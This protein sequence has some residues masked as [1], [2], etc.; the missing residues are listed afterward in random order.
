M[1]TQ[2][3]SPS[4]I[5]KIILTALLITTVVYGSLPASPAFASTFLVNDLS[6]APDASLDGICD[7]SPGDGIE[8][9]TLRA[10]IMEAN[11]VND[12]DVITF[13][14]PMT[15][16]LGSALPTITQPVT[17]DGTSSGGRITLNGGGAPIY[18]FEIQADSVTIKG[19]SLVNFDNHAIQ[20]TNGADGV[21]INNNYIG[22]GADGT[23]D[24]GN[25]H[26]G[27]N[28]IDSPNATISTNLISG[29][30][31][32]GIYVSGAD[33]DGLTI[34]GNTIGLNSAGTARLETDNTLT[35]AD[36]IRLSAVTN[37]TVGGSSGS[38]R[39]VVSGNYGLGIV[40]TGDSTGTKVNGNYV[41]TNAIG[42]D[43]IGNMDGGVR[44]NNALGVSVGTT[45]GNL[46]SGNDASAV[47]V[48]GTSTSSVANN[49]I[50]LDI[51]GDTKLANTG[52]GIGVVNSDNINIY[53]NVISGNTSNGI[54]VTEGSYNLNINDNRI[55]VGKTLDIDLGNSGYGIRLD[56]SNNNLIGSKT[57]SLGNMIAYNGNDGIFIQNT[58]PGSFNSYG[59]SIVGNQIFN[60]A[61]LGIDLAPNGPTLNDA[62]DP[63]DGPNYLQN[64]ITFTA[65]QTATG[66]Q[67]TG[68]LNTDILR[69][70]YRIEFFV[71]NSCDASGYGEGAELVDVLNIL[72]A[73]NPTAIDYEIPDTTIS[74]G[75]YL[76]ATVTYDEGTGGLKDTSEFS[77]CAVVQEPDSPGSSGVFVVNSTL[78]T[79]E[80]PADIGDGTCDVGGGVCTLRAALQ[81]AN[82]GVEPPY[83]ISFNISGTAPHTISLTAP[84]PTINTPVII[85]GKPSGYLGQPVIIVDGSGAGGGNGFTVSAVGSSIDGLSVVNFSGGSG[86]EVNANNVVLK[87]NY[88][89]LL[90]NGTTVAGNQMGITVNNVTGTLV[91]NNVVAGNTHGIRLVGTGAQDNTVLNN[92]VGT[93][94]SGTLD[95]GNTSDGIRLE[96]SNNNIIEGNTISGNTND[97]IEVSGGA[98]N[99]AINGNK[100]GVQALGSNNL[101]NNGHG[102]NVNNSSNNLITN[103]ISAYN[104]SAGVYISTG[105]QNLIS[106]NSIYG[107]SG[108]GIQLANNGNN[109]TP[110]PQMFSALQ[111][112]NFIYIDGQLTGALPSTTYTLEFFKN[113]SGAQGETLI[114]TATVTT[115]GA[116]S[117]SFSVGIIVTVPDLTQITATATD[118]SNNT[119]M[120]SNG[121]YVAGAAPTLTPTPTPVPTSTFTPVPSNTPVPTS[122]NTAVPPTPTA[123]TSGGGGGGGTVSTA[124]KTK[125]PTITNTPTITFTPTLLSQYQT[126]TQLAAEN[127]I[128]PTS[129]PETPTATLVPSPTLVSTSAPPTETPAAAAD[130]GGISPE[131]DGGVPQDGS[132]GGGD[133]GLLSGLLGGGGVTTIL[134]IFIILAALLL[135]IGGG[136]ELMRWMNSRD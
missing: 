78:D 101:G 113:T 81:E 116:G 12:I 53:G 122:T 96:G 1:N 120:F 98:S 134:W 30:D 128:E 10:A 69:T 135:L 13:T 64:F 124:T 119:S 60:N 130:D 3:K 123:T 11:R 22:V 100:I 58:N 133:G 109:N 126:L 111:G 42:E 50:G 117:A 19:F 82:A 39:N 77:P 23:S 104:G 51:D 112:G 27:V 57:A 110:A 84:L 21:V 52:Y 48:N 56:N 54:N 14:V 61:G 2:L 121:V 86:F 25:T 45:A 91:R 46:V 41:G 62:D 90:A 75:D 29:N 103:N 17:I 127:T 7:I 114:H 102:I 87:N 40:I 63:D 132:T 24:G 88:V 26:R 65:K 47:V 72:F 74:A 108:L 28:I 73:T 55:G 105:T 31:M 106:A 79:A 94:S 93:D 70:N 35:N 4:K 8:N 59:N 71:N 115:S 43:A 67:I 107:N 97:G 20:V 80:A 44:L 38:T 99:N 125:T 85:K 34:T 129:T 32:G 9:C 136:M 83:T 118:S 16:N 92:F 95:R 37:A 66:V 89:G 15:L 6:D 68:S 18:G 36:G 5:I 76:T 49:T 33:S 131:A